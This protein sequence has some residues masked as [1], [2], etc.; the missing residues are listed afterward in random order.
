MHSVANEIRGVIHHH[1]GALEERKRELLERVDAVR[2]AKLGAL[3]MQKEELRKYLASSKNTLEQA[4]KLMKTAQQQKQRQEDDSETVA[5]LRSVLQEQLQVLKTSRPCLQP[6]EDDQLSFSAP[7][8][9]ILK[10]VR[11]LGNIITGA[12]APNC[13][14]LGDPVRR[15]IKDKPIYYTV[16]ARDHVGEQLTTG[17]DQVNAFVV[18]SSGGGGDGNT[19]DAVPQP[20][21]V[22]DKKNGTY[23]CRY[24]PT[25]G[26]EHQVSTVFGI[27]G[28]FCLVNAF[29]FRST[30]SCEAARFEAVH[31]R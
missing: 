4:E 8:P 10:T 31:S 28:F 20:V 6:Q 12:Y 19:I 3:N 11:L 21:D 24:E 14:L 27:P 23:L 15:A 9:S 18:A 7:D 2:T 30:F 29:H 16:Q 22:Y 17:G 26:G 5:R 25:Q 13:T 1:I